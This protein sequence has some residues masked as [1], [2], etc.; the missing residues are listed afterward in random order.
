MLIKQAMCLCA[1]CPTS[2]SLRPKSG[3]G[4]YLAKLGGVLRCLLEKSIWCY[5]N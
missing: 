5:Q 1:S 4:V 2:T 3:S